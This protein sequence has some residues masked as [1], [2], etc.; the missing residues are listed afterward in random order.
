MSELS[1]KPG[2]ANYLTESTN[3]EAVHS[4]ATVR[5][6]LALLNY[7]G[8]AFTI[9]G[10]GAPF[11]AKSFA[12]DQTEIARMYAW[13]S[14]NAFG[15]LFLARMADRVGRRRILIVSLIITP[16]CSALAA[17]S[18]NI[19]WFIFF[20]ILAYAAVGATFASSFVMLAEALPIADRAKG[21][22]YAL[23]AISCGG[24]LCVILAPILAHF[25]W[26]WRWLLAVPAVGIV[27][28]PVIIRAIPESER[29]QRA[30]ASGVT[31]SSHF[32]DVFSPT[33]RRRTI[34]LF[35]AVLMGEFSGA[36]IA[37]W[38]FYHATTEVGLSSAMTSMVMLVGGTL[39]IIGLVI[40]AWASER[41]GRVKSIVVLGLATMLGSLAYYWG[42][43]T[44][45]RSPMLWLIVGQTWL[46]AAGRG[47]VVASN[48]AATELFPTA[49]RG[50]I[51]G[52][53][54]LCVAIAAVAAQI[55][56]SAL[57]KPLG[58]LSNVVGWLSL[59]LIPTAVIWYF[60]IE[61]TQGLSLESSA[62][63]DER[64]AAV[65]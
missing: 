14:L 11:I 31:R 15:A 21:Q 41:Y 28:L 60:F 2:A 16:V 55:T 37:A 40:G 46:S 38:P 53:I 32:Y 36:G 61:E 56:I 29:W 45:F 57:A 62:H 44:H 10:V 35:A 59:L 34:P 12:L 30:A 47:S 18:Y 9:L 65:S 8:Y 5:A 54:G 4:R 1:R 39:G 19:N 17:L 33:W 43:P 13:I 6:I 48:S 3:G 52:W 7:Q 42:P 58:G 50:T 27:L 24:G 25:G 63:E 51:M 26:S 22:G 49:L 23:F 20:E 64:E